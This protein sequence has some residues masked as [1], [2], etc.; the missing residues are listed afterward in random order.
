M[1]LQLKSKLKSEEPFLLTAMY[2]SCSSLFKLSII[3]EIKNLKDTLDTT[4]DISRLLKHSPKRE[5]L[6]KTLKKEL[7]PGTPGFRI[8]CKTRFAVRAAS[9]QSVINI[10]NV[11]QE[12]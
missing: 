7:A 12:L 3:Y 8:L 2:I 9:L 1:V 10:W 6:F 4:F 5:T 11:F